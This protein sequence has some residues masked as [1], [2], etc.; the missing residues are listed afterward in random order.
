MIMGAISVDPAKDTQGLADLN[1][2]QRD[3]LTDA[4]KNGVSHSLQACL[5]EVLSVSTEEKPAFQYRIQ[6]AKLSAD[7]ASAVNKA[8]R[9]DLS[10]LTAMETNMQRGILAP[11][12]T[13]MQSLASD[14]AKRGL[15]LKLNLI[16]ILNY[17][18]VAEL[19]RNS[20]VVTD[21]VSGDVTIKDTATS[22]QISAIV[23]QADRR[24]ALRKVMFDSVLATA[25]YRAGKAVMLPAI[26][27]E[28]VHLALNKSADR[29]TV[30]G[31]LHWLEALNLMTTAEEQTALGGFVPGQQL[32]CLLRTGFAEN[33]CDAMFFDGS[34]KLYPQSHYLEIGR[35]ALLSL[36]DTTDSVNRLRAQLLSD[37]IWPQAVSIGAVAELGDLVGVQRDDSRVPVLIGDVY[38][39]SFWAEAMANAGQ[40]IDQ[41]RKAA[42][43][44][45]P[46]V[47]IQNADFN[48]KR[49]ALQKKLAD[50]VKASKMRFDQPWGMLCLYRAAGA[51]PSAYGRITGLKMPLERGV[52]RILA[53]GTSGS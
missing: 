27:C 25:A 19:I 46:K 11:G 48:A 47:L 38:D 14:T 10:A 20:E 41:T 34:G 51:P 32:T 30:N 2:T 31:Y 42:G 36:L 3:A 16:G 5:E 23:N 50:V 21:E 28:Q 1:K 26:T 8:L 4:L 15:T 43:T 35:N 6:P 7:A 44:S 13:M 17:S 12:L 37:G 29:A 24:E 52:Q 39:I 22:N 53:A 49:Q 9:G 33:D 40:L 45:D 18:S